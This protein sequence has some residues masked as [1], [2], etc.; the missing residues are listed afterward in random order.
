M[1][2]VSTITAA[3]IEAHNKQFLYS[4]FEGWAKRTA[5]AIDAEVLAIVYK[6]KEG[7]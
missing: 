1:D 7:E 3:E 5:E 2:G 6:R 4:A